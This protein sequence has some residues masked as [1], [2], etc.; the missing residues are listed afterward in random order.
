MHRLQMGCVWSH[1]T[2][3]LR[4]GYDPSV[5]NFP[6]YENFS[7][8]SREE[9]A[10][11]SQAWGRPFGRRSKGDSMGDKYFSVSFN[12]VRSSGESGE[13]R[14]VE[15]RNRSAQDLTLGFSRLDPKIH[16]LAGLTGSRDLIPPSQGVPDPD[17]LE[18]INQFERV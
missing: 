15:P 6:Q 5:S 11:T 3:R 13:R 2:L 8:L 17:I 1:A 12:G 14:P 16:I 4:H 18:T 7:L 10:L 9:L